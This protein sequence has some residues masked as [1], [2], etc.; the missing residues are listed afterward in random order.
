MGLA[1]SGGMVSVAAGLGVVEPLLPAGVSVAAVNG[2]SATVVSGP[3]EGLEEF[4]QRCEGVAR[5]RVLPVDYAS[6]GPAVEVLEDELVR[7]LDGIRPQ[8]ATVRFFS[9]VTGGWV[10]GEEL[11][12]GYWYRNLRQPVLL[13]RAVEVLLADGFGVFVECS[14]HPVLT[15]AIG[16]RD[17]VHATG[18]LRRDHGDWRQVLTAVGQAHVWGVPVD[19]S[20]ALPGQYPHVDLPTYPFQHERFWPRL[21]ASTGD[22]AGLGLAATGHPLLGA[23]MTLP[24][25]TVFTSVLSTNTVPWLAD[26]VVAGTV[27]FPGTGFAEL[28]LHAGQDAGCPYVRELTLHAAL[29]V[30]DAPIA[31]R[32][33]VLDADE[34]GDRRIVIHSQPVPRPDAEWTHHASAV[35][36]SVPGATMPAVAAE[37]PP[38][39]TPID[40]TGFYEA[41]ADG[42]V[43]YGPAFQGVR[44]AWRDGEDVVAQVVLAD[45]PGGHHLHPALFD[46]ALHS[47]GLTG[48]ELV[49]AGPQLPF[50]F[51]GLSLSATGAT[52]L[53]VRL[54]PL[55]PGRVALA[56]AD[57]SGTPVAAV[58]ELTLRPAPSMAAG[59]S[60]LYR[61]AWRPAPTTAQPAR[62]ELYAAGDPFGL[63]AVTVDEGADTALLPVIG[64]DAHETVR[65][66]LA[67]LQAWLSDPKTTDR[68]LAVVTRHAVAT[69]AG[70]EAPDPVAG[71]VWGLVRSAQSEHP[72]RFVLADVDGPE[73]IDALPA[74][75]ASGEPELA[76][77]A[78]AV[79]A[80]RLVRQAP[81][82]GPAPW[83]ASGRVLITGGT[84]LLGAL[85]ARHLVRVHG[86][87]ELLLVS[88]SG[89]AAEG[90][91]DL[92][93]ELA[94]VGARVEVVAC[95]TADRQALR[96]VLDAYPI[97]AV[98][99]AAGVLDDGVV[100]NLTPDRLAAVLRPK[101]DAARLLDELTRDRPLT[102]F[103]L[104]SSFAGLMGAA[105]QA[106][107]AA[108]NSYL[109]TLAAR[110]MAQGLPAHSIAWGL[111]S[112]ASAMTGHLSGTDRVRMSRAGMTPLSNGDGLA[113]LDAALVAG[114]PVVAAVTLDLPALR[115]AGAV[116]ALLTDLVR[117]PLRKAAAAAPVNEL[118]TLDRRERETRL[119]T[120]IRELVAAILGHGSVDRVEPEHA[121]KELGFDS[122]MAVELR[123]RLAAVVGVRLPATL[124][125]DFPTPQALA[126]YVSGLFGA[127]TE[128]APERSVAARSDTDPIVIVGM[129]CRYPGG[130]RSPEALWSLVAAETDAVGEWPVDRGWDVDALYDPDPERSGTSYARQ[131]C[132][133]YDATEFDAGFF[134]IS[135]REALAMD[136]QQRLLLETSWEAVERAGIDPRSLRGS[137][138]GVFAG[139]MYF[140]YAARLSS[141]PEGVEGYLGTGSSGSVASGRIS[142]SLGLEGPAITVDT[143][144]SSSLVALHLAAQSLRQG[145]CDL[146]LAGGATVLSTPALFI[147][148]SR[149]RGMAV[150]G[151]CKSFAA[152]ADGTGWGE[153]VGVLLLE[154]LSDA[155]RQ[156]HPVLAVVRGSAVNQDGAS[157]GLTAPNGPSQQRVIQAALSAAGLASGDVDAV[158]GHGTGTRLGDP[159]EVQALLATYGRDRDPDRPLW[160]GSIKSN[161]GHT[162]AAAGVAGVIKMVMAMH[163]GTL[164]R[165]LH[166]DAPSDQVDWASGEVR[167][168][169]AAR[170]WTVGG[171]RPRRAAV[172]SFGISGT[173]AHVVLEQ[174]APAEPEPA[175][176]PRRPEAPAYAWGVSAQSSMALRD[177]AR[178]LAGHVAGAD[179]DPVDVGYSLAVS[180]T[181]W[182]HRAVVH[183][184]D[185]DALLAGLR[186]IAEGEPS[187]YVEAGRSSSGRLAMLFTGQGAQRPGMG[188]ALAA[189]YPAYAD[190][191]DAACGELDRYL[192]RPLR[193]V[194][195]SEPELLGRTRYTQPAL[196]AT[197]V[198]LFALLRGWGLAPD[199]VTGHSIGEIAAAH[200]AGV[201]TL[202]DAAALVGARATLMDALPPGGVMIAVGVSESEARAAMPDDGSV[203]VAAVNGPTS[204]VLSGD[205]GPTEAVAGALAAAGARIR[206]L[207]VSHAFHSERMASMLD[208]FGDA[209]AGLSFHSPRIPMV[210]AVTGRFEPDAVRDPGYW[211][212]QV[213]ATVRFADAVRSLDEAGAATYLE[214]GPDAVLSAMVRE[215]LGA[216]T[217]AVAA[218]RRDRPDEAATT[219]ALAALHV[220]GAPIDWPAFYADLGARRVDLPTYAFQ[221][222]KYWLDATPG[223]AVPVSPAVGPAGPVEAEVDDPAERL[224]RDLAT[225]DVAERRELVL[226]HV[227]LAAAATL[228]FT[229][230]DAVEPDA[231]FLE[232]GFTSLGVME[233]RNRLTTLTGVPLPA[234]L[235]WDHPTAAH[236]ADHL[237]E[238][239]RPPAEDDAPGTLSLLFDQARAQGRTDEFR[240][241]LLASEALRPVLAEAPEPGRVSA[242]RL[243]DSPDGPVLVCVGSP[244]GADEFADEVAARFGGLRTVLAAPQPRDGDAPAGSRAVA[245]ELLAASLRP[246]I[247]DRP[248][249]VVAHGS[250]WL[251]AQELTAWLCAAGHEV[252]GFVRVDPAD[253]ERELAA[254][255][256][257]STERVLFDL[258]AQLRLFGGSGDVATEVPSVTVSAGPDDPAGAQA[259]HEWLASTAAAR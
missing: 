56:A 203:S 79:L 168:L 20:V 131:G 241:V 195:A 64:T 83:S 171:D 125:F 3:V 230:A 183:G 11:D 104:F 92:V 13:D 15:V 100:T 90:A 14:A 121:F 137:R 84:G 250:G 229:Q 18:T 93:A 89:L 151:R 207:T 186:A 245:A 16:E 165:T 37:P 216:D 74:A 148:F 30:A 120:L 211:V 99:H 235:I 38:G 105:G 48:V 55:G 145:E 233:L 65:S 182:P 109:D 164:P 239:L 75:V 2:P 231:P 143:A 10:S 228:G 188:L 213:R 78:G 234:G 46:A 47:C 161:L 222:E 174:P 72:G 227:L 205:E 194:I 147:E 71:A 162:Q 110:R 81:G 112:E 177:Q 111:W 192:D 116:P 85:V 210:S 35:V 114:E 126:A 53:W 259:L 187:P 258:A 86:V 60:T 117:V 160:L 254:L 4:R 130:V 9:T 127:P 12:A 198:A 70:D 253:P 149:Q 202:P 257:R 63:A 32:V 217:R 80:P 39:A 36:S 173:N 106:A 22:P 208:D 238:H 218:L 185:R 87:R 107:Y 132:F 142:Y 232:L 134:G 67:T 252:D 240:A 62:C 214:V 219:A 77:R 169:C 124:V 41:L 40:L 97:D 43:E 59:G 103:V 118:A 19:W 199:F 226:R 49:G 29:P 236:V 209:L 17:G 191:F 24:D 251:P 28:V 167:L 155:R 136:P 5:A 113:A 23:V 73:S 34:A 248:V 45:E 26:H 175:P 158:E 223:A 242:R 255:P 52:E 54:R 193:D 88:R 108:A 172:S 190:A 25:R 256:P 184:P 243:A 206:R 61:V 246:F 153:G 94:E 7:V 96:A 180:R 119:L 150:D 178:T 6:H 140:D 95:D 204:I 82:E 220:H 1:G 123:N 33:T 141:L 138:T 157:N 139:L 27:L 129:A 237:L 159:I 58:E 244:D 152:A 247:E 76:I 200:V 215:T 144:C 50:N 91:A 57:P 201:L 156:G 225:L 102:A 212:N 21:A 101:V 8:S 68:R 221:R 179:L 128:D 69:G 249:V 122:L 170:E 51:S 66:V 135:P 44:A 176:A 224:R 133:L 154:R 166:V 189:R 197:E 42:G 115:R 196:F 181:T 98:V 31:L 163:A 146:A